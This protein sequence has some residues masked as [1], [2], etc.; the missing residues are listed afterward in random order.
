MP[1]PVLFAKAVAASGIVSAIISAV[2]TLLWRPA[3]ATR[4]NAA[5][6]LGAACGAV[7]GY[8]VLGLAPHWPPMDGLD[9]CLCI[10]LPAALVIELIAG[11][12]RVPRLLAWTMRI[13]LA[14]VAGRVLLHGS[15]YLDGSS[16]EW[17]TGQAWIALVACAVLLIAVWALLVW[18]MQRL[19]RGFD[20]IGRV[21][22]VRGRRHVP[23]A[24]GLSHR[25]Q[26]GIGRWLR[27]WRERQWAVI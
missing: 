22:N 25:R 10:V 21:A 1:D 14:A 15:S 2:L 7:A 18:L 19:R 20:F 12:G 6:I 5:C 23:D 8:R 11:F 4:V 13:V 24:L 17:T 27:A 9:R 26:S 3:S 16:S